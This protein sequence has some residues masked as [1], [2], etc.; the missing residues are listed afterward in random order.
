MLN[1]TLSLCSIKACLFSNSISPCLSRCWTYLESSERIK[2]DN[3]VFRGKK[4]K[5]KKETKCFL[6]CSPCQADLSDE[7]LNDIPET[8]Q[9]SNMRFFA[10][11]QSIGAPLRR[12]LQPSL[13]LRFVPWVSA[14]R[15]AVSAD[16]RLW[17]RA[18]N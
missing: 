10:P 12:Y 13:L 2:A 17:H 1:F 4:K 14:L 8:S 9:M 3:K 7:R 16:C 15:K 5:G 18:G 6:L 11:I